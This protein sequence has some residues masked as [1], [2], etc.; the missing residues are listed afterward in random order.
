MKSE[1]PHPTFGD[2]IQLEGTS[3]NLQIDPNAYMDVYYNKETPG[4]RETDQS[5]PVP[6]LN[7][8][9]L[10]LKSFFRTKELARPWTGTELVALYVLREKKTHGAS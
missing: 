10:P 6:A 1:V 2:F 3:A 4:R 5:Y 9:L 8:G 7:R